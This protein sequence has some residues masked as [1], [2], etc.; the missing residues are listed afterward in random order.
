MVTIYACD[1]AY[2]AVRNGTRRNPMFNSQY[3][4][5]AH[6]DNGNRCIYLQEMPPLRFL[7]AK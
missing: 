4:W 6:D 5:V 7:A 2:E 3:G 1:D